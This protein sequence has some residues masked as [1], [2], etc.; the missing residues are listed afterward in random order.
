MPG[1]AELLQ[2]EARGT[3]AKKRRSKRSQRPA[4]KKPLSYLEGVVERIVYSN[5]ETGYAVLRLQAVGR[6]DWV[7]VV[8]N[9]PSANSGET[10]R[11]SGQWTFHPQFG[12]QFKVE[13]YQSVVPATLNGIE[14][15]LG[16][17]L[18]KGIGPIMASRIV[19]AFG[20]KTLEA[21]DT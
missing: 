9:L 19:R 6:R 8:G 13:A 16:S 12:E 21:I 4:E 10:L 3:P 18:I 5:E 17:G 1:S 15:Y 14:K 7:T 2:P 11:L 20:L